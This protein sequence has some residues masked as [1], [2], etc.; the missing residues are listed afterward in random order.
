[1]SGTISIYGFP[2]GFTLLT[3]YSTYTYVFSDIGQLGTSTASAAVVGGPA[4]YTWTVINE[5][6]ILGGTGDGFDL[7]GGVITNAGSALIQGSVAAVLFDGGPGTVLNSGTLLSTASNG[8]AVYFESAG[9]LDNQAGAEILAGY[10]GVYGSGDVVDVLNSGTIASTVTDGSAIQLFAGGAVTN[11]VG[12]TLTGDYGI[13]IEGGTDPSVLNAGLISADTK[14]GVYLGVSANIVNQ[15]GGT[16][17]GTWGIGA[18]GGPTTSITNDGTIVGS[19]QLGL[20][21]VFLNG[22]GTVENGADGT[23]GGYFGI[24]SLGSSAVTVLNAGSIVGTSGDAIYLASGVANRVVLE[25]GAV[26]DGVVIGGSLGSGSVLDLAVGTVAGTVDPIGSAFLGFD[27]LT[28]DP[29]AAWNLTGTNTIAALTDDGTLAIASGVAL[30]VGGSVIVGANA[31]LD[32]VGGS[33]SADT[34]ENNGSA[35]VGL[36]S[37]TENVVLENL[38]TV[39]IVGG[40]GVWT[41][42]MVLTGTDGGRGAWQIG[43]A[44]TLVIN[45]NTVDAGQEIDFQ[46]ASDDP[47]LVIGQQVDG[48][49]AGTAGVP[50]WIDPAAPNLLLNG[51]FQASIVDFQ[52][53]DSIQF[54]N[55]AFS[56]VD[57]VNG[58]TVTL[59]DSANDPL[60]SLTF[61]DQQ[62]NASDAGAQAASS[63]ISADAACFA[64]GTRLQTTRGAIPVED[65]KVGDHLIRI[66]GSPAPVTWIG[67]W[68]IDCKTW[69]NPSLVWPVRVDRDTLGPGQPERA[70]Y[71]SPDH[72]IFIDDVLIP[73]KYLIDGNNIVQ[74]ETDTVT[75]FHVELDRHSVISAEGL[76]VESYLEMDMMPRREKSDGLRLFPAS[77]QD[78]LLDRAAIWEMCG[79]A[80][81]V[82]SGRRLAAAKDR[83]RAIA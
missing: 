83:I 44:G 40:V 30:N 11:A 66:D 47:T 15:S 6:T 42:P 8:A 63:Q 48:G 18:V 4:P 50:A 58:N 20:S 51:G 69:S 79:A 38:G 55:L 56:T 65:L 36:G 14:Y 43:D 61:L 32:N 60:G 45:A 52:V 19:D 21:G 76:A 31:S 77:R 12:G 26:F 2:D 16:I 64:L 28:V 54:T 78:E 81:L 17:E 59:F 72:A 5:G 73:V 29:S 9:T 10:D 67:R 80:P 62:G 22:G 3:N 71:L 24:A 74:V 41:A 35:N 34:F 39:Q 13:V 46:S 70:V 82:I 37:N 25:P 27:T 75:Y 33:V 53:G 1:M 49:G 68:E 57:V 7:S 23:I